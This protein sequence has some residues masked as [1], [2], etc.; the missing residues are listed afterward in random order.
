MEKKIY[1]TAGRQKLISFLAANPDRQFTTEE[2]CRAVRGDSQRGKSS[3]YRQLQQLC[4]EQILCK[5][6][7]EELGCSVYQYV[8]EGCSCRSHFHG[9]CT[10]CGSVMHLECDDS[11]A[12]AAHLL[13]AHGFAIDCGQSMLYG[14]CA[15]CRAQGGED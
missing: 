3:T 14:V 15:T 4:D 7:N 1:R 10:V 8:G 5:F 13:R 12:F 11:V 2:L 9:K 6:R